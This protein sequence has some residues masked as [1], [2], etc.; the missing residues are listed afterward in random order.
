MRLFCRAKSEAHPQRDVYPH[1]DYPDHHQR[2][3]CTSN[4]GYRGH[5]EAYGICRIVSNETILLKGLV[6]SLPSIKSPGMIKKKEEILEAV[7]LMGAHPVET[8]DVGFDSLGVAKGI[9][10]SIKAVG[11]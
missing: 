1:A 3:S 5:Y 7:S 2:G 6:L 10:A 8:L 11:L 9:L 4:F